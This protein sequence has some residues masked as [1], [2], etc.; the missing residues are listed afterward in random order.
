MFGEMK[1]FSF[2]DLVF[3]YFSQGFSALGK[4]E[5]LYFSESV[6]TIAFFQF[7]PRIFPTVKPYSAVFRSAFLFFPMFSTFIE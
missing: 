6:Q 1:L 2:I 7:H 3:Y 5:G 4:T